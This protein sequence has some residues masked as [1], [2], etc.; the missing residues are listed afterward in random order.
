MKSLFSHFPEVIMVHHFF[1]N[2]FLHM[3]VYFKTK[4]DYVPQMCVVCMPSL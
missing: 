1:Q 4:C 2:F 3:K